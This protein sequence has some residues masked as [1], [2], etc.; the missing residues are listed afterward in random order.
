MNNNTTIKPKILDIK[1][2]LMASLPSD[3]PTIASSTILAGAGS[4]PAFNTL[5]KS[6]VSL[7][8]K[9]PE[10]VETPPPISF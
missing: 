1:P 8:V 3:G 2:L 5:A 4:L 9:L 6:F 10:I 7:T